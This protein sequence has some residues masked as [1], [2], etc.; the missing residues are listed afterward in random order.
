MH[1][2]PR[3]A[4]QRVVK[5][6]VAVV[7]DANLE[8][9]RAAA[10]YFARLAESVECHAKLAKD[11][12]LAKIIQ[13][14]SLEDVECQEVSAFALAHLASDRDLQVPLVTLGA[15]KPLVAMMSATRRISSSPLSF[16]LPLR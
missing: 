3:P 8:I 4:P 6:F 13:I 7:G 2:D 14:A 1:H 11:G 12:A 16:H 9:K 15:L 5:V 10:Y